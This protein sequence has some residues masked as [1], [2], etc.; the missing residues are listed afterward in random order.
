LDAPSYAFLSYATSLFQL[1]TLHSME[2]DESFAKYVK[3]KRLGT[4]WHF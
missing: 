1:Q 3:W 2:T 4:K